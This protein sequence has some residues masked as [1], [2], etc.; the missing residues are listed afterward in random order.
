[1]LGLIRP[2]IDRRRSGRSSGGL[3]Q[4]WQGCCGRLYANANCRKIS[5][6]CWRTGSSRVKSVTVDL[7]V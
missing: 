1:M 3:W 7:A 4:S 5:S 2:I 6:L